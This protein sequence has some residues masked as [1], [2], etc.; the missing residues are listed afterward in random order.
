MFVKRRSHVGVC[1]R[2]KTGS[3]H[4]CKLLA[5]NG[6]FFADRFCFFLSLPC[7][8]RLKISTN[9]SSRVRSWPWRRL[10]CEN[11][12]PSSLGPGAKKD[13]CFRRLRV[14]MKVRLKSK[15]TRGFSFSPL[16]GSLAAHSC[17]RWKV[18]KNLPTY[19]P[20]YLPNR[21]LTRGVS[22]AS[23]CSKPTPREIGAQLLK[24][25]I[26]VNQCYKSCTLH[27]RVLNYHL[28]WRNTVP[29]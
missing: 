4:V 7:E 1:E 9:P 16:R 15:V 6:N 5:S 2:Y 11:S 20:T 3:K 29:L 17:M 23:N 25:E 27:C 14:G 10:A 24:I 8:V 13:G 19:L 28:T 18:K 22:L 12:H 21:V 26:K